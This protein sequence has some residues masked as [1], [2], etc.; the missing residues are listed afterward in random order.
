MSSENFSDL[1]IGVELLKKDMSFLTTLFDKMDKLIQKIETQQDNIVDKTNI[2]IDKQMDITKDQFAEIYALL[3]NTESAINNR[4]HEIEKLMKEDISE[5]KSDLESH[6]DNEDNLS[7][8]VNKIIYFGSGV[9]LL[10][11]WVLENL[12]LV[13]KFLV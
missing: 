9:G 3:N 1:R 8:K 10:L 5:L 6:I 7:K 2:I 12:D 4:I 11:L 13:K